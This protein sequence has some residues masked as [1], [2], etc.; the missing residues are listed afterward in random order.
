MIS[1]KKTLQ[2]SQQLQTNKEFYSSLTIDN[3]YKDYYD[4]IHEQHPL[5]GWT[6]TR[7]E[8]ET[9]LKHLIKSKVLHN[10]IDII[11]TKNYSN[12]NNQSNFTHQS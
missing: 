9:V 11:V 2:A 12:I 6:C 3:L 7:G 8:Y 4:S 10:L 1:N 5:G